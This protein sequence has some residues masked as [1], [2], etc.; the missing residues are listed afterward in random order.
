MGLSERQEAII[1]KY[2]AENPGGE[3]R[4]R[5]QSEERAKE[6]EARAELM[7]ARKA[8]Q[9]AVAKRP[10]WQ[11]DPRN[12]DACLILSPIHGVGT[13]I[14]G[15]AY[16]R[17]DP[18]K[19]GY[20]SVFKGNHPDVPRFPF[21]DNVQDATEALKTVE[22]WLQEGLERIAVDREFR[23][24]CNAFSEFLI[25]ELGL[26]AGADMYAKFLHSKF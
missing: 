4:A 10:G 20:E 2:R 11:Y 15:I 6:R 24:T 1:A 21:T 12:G 8:L 23:E 25:A 18:E 26:D 3:E 22:K 7:K 19:S 9:E 5:V 13:R 17:A 16:V 14:G